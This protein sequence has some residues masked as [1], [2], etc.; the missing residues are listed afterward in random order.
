MTNTINM[1]SIETRNANLCNGWATN[2]ECGKL[3]KYFIEINTVFSIQKAESFLLLEN[4]KS[5]YVFFPKN[6]LSIG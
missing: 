1:K 2:S 3:F 5:L 4:T 6:K